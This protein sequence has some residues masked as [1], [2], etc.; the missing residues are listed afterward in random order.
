[1]RRTVLAV[2]ITLGACFSGGY[3][4]AKGVS[5]LIYGLVFL[6]GAMASY[7]LYNCG[8]GE[9]ASRGIGIVSE[10]PVENLPIGRYQ[11]VDHI[12]FLDG[13]STTIVIVRKLAA[14]GSLQ[15]MKP[16]VFMAYRANILPDNIFA[17][18]KEKK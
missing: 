4:A 6:V 5:S 8:W 11:L 10:G 12:N 15:G 14:K 13:E 1:M 2:I 3:L 17:V 7:W 9:G 16:N 18:K